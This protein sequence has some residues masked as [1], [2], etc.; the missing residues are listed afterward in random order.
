[1]STPTKLKA[2]AL[3]LHV[4]GYSSR[5][6]VKRLRAKFPGT[7]I[8]GHCTVNRWVRLTPSASSTQHVIAGACWAEVAT[9]AGELVMERAEEMARVPYDQAWKFYSR[10]MEVALLVQDRCRS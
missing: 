2:E 3:A 9:L 7:K 8:P 5:D 4:M 6:I 10:A 1:V